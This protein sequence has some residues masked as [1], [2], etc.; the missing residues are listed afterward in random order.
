MIIKPEQNRAVIRQDGGTIFIDIPS[1]KNIPV[2]LFLSL[3]LVGW[4][5][6]VY[7]ATLSLMKSHPAGG[8]FILVWLAFWIFGGC[9]A[10]GT[11]LWNLFGKESIQL[12]GQFISIKQHVFGIGKLKQY[13][14]SD[15]KQLRIVALPEALMKINGA[16]NN[17][18]GITG[19]LAFDYGSKTYSFARDIDEAEAKEILKKILMR[20]PSLDE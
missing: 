3:W 5:F 6:G 18:P 7:T 8:M 13:Q 17:M 12:D 11:I 19:R 2:M 15:I 20:H 1:T 4:A 10:G 14:V 16:F 9:F